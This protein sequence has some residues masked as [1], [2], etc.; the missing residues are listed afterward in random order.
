VPDD[1]SDRRRGALGNVGHHAYRSTQDWGV[2]AVDGPIRAIVDVT[3]TRL[4]EGHRSQV[5]IELDFSGH[6]IGKLLVPLMV[7]PSARKEMP[8][9]LQRLKQQLERRE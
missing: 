1:A 3:V 6:G 2:R 5:T 7:R 8:A 9:N 4:K